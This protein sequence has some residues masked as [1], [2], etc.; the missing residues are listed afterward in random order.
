[1]TE[2]YFDN[3]QEVIENHISSANNMICVA[4]AWFTN[5]VLLKALTDA[6]KRKVKIKVLILDDILNRNEFGLD[7][8]FLINNGAAVNFANSKSGTMHNKFCIVDNVVITGS[9]NWTYHANK[10]NE[11]ILVTDKEYIV[12]AYVEEFER[13][14]GE[15]TPISLPYEHLRWTDVKEGDFSE[16]RRNIFR[17]VIAK[18]DENR[19]LKRIKLI[20]LDNA[21]K[22]GDIN[23]LDKASAL[24]VREQLRTI[25]DVLVS[26]SRDFTFMLWKEN[27]IGVPFGN[28]VDGYGHIGEWYFIPIS[29][30]RDN[31]NR[32]HI[33]GILKTKAGKKSRY[34]PGYNLDIYDIEFIAAIKK[35]LGNESLSQISAKLIPDNMLRI[36]KAKMFFYQFSTPMF[37][38]SQPRTKKNGAPRTISA[39]NLFG[40]VREEDGDNA[41]FY[42]GWDPQKRG[43]EI[44]KKFFEKG[45]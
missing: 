35:N 31:S 20:N 22:S 40:I 2:S 8:G 42:Q 16:L 3:I 39:I 36:D 25:M 11:N 26:H 4:V 24:P 32:E 23:E 29:I 28:N 43:E 9:Y 38:Q 14:F 12:N 21:Y 34:M 37:N 18:N 10:N 17:D 45:L 19:E 27:E 30:Q 44:A 41:V 1:M 33:K 5:D 7:Y 13:L 15:G 6:L